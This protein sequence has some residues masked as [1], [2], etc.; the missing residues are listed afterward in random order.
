M[1]KG[2]AQEDEEEVQV[3]MVVVVVLKVGAGARLVM[4]PK[5][6]GA[7]LQIVLELL[8]D[9][10]SNTRLPKHYARAKLM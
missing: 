5:M 6:R 1:N 2:A 10:I 3:L 4:R 8:P 7:Y 9:T